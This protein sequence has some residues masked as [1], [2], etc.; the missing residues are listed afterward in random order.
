MR[1]NSGFTLVELLAIIV[2]LAVIIAIAAP[3]MTKQIS[4]SDQ[5]KNDVFNQK[6]ENA[7]HLYAAKY[8][9][10]KLV[11]KEPVTFTLQALVDDGLI[12]LKNN[13]CQ[14]AGNKNKLTQNI[15][16]DSSLKYNYNNINDDNCYVCQNSDPSGNNYC[17]KK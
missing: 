3:N 4:K 17:I 14:G 6:I 9:A 11:E 8:Y 12:T 1:K 7:A 10:D 16:V 5:E 15:S 13:K 2:I